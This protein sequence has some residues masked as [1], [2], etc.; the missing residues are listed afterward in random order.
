[1]KQ[2]T[3]TICLLALTVVTLAYLGACENDD[4]DNDADDDD[5]AGDDDN[6]AGD[7]DNDTDADD[8]DDDD[9][10]VDDDTIGDDDSAEEIPDECKI[11][12]NTEPLLYAVNV[13]VNGETVTQ[14]Y[15]ATTDDELALSL[16]YYD[17][18]CNLDTI[19]G[20]PEDVF[21]GHLY[22]FLDERDEDNL[23][24]E[25]IAKLDHHSWRLPGIGCSSEESGPYV[26][27]L[28]PQDWV[29]DE[30]EVREYPFRVRLDDACG[31]SSLYAYVDFTVNPAE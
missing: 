2:W 11:P 8:I 29:V 4:D 24:P 30:T 12:T 3:W 16:E 6:D 31:A 10:V 20:L 28:D 22:V 14:P 17:A 1:M 13:I 5:D 15:T 9:D 26:I 27:E 21:S 19:P 18:Q 25:A 7:D 23:S